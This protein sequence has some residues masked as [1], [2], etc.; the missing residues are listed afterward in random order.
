M[1]DR[2]I[3]SFDLADKAVIITGAAGGIGRCVAKTFVRAGAKLLLAD[4]QDE[5]VRD[6]AAE[7]NRDGAQSA[8]VAAD[9]VDSASLATMVETAITKLGAVDVL[10]HCAGLDAPRANVWE[11][12]DELWDRIIDIDLSSAWRCAKAVIGH[13][14][15]RRSGRIIYIGSIAGRGASLTTAVAYNA[16]KAGLQGLT[17]GLA[18]QLEPHGILVNTIA[19]GP[20]GTGELMTEAELEADHVNFPIPIQGAQPVAD[21]CLY[22]AGPGG[23]WV[24][25]TVLNVSGGRWHG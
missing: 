6:L 20:T 14:A 16:A 17:V 3:P 1:I 12:N 25:G 18:K 22:L 4:I 7:L 10:I 9:V 2:K 13:M 8:A 24:S 19:P 21:A 5:K 15:H 23:S 11:L